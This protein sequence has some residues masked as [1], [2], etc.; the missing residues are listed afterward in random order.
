M[1]F[2]IL[3]LDAQGHKIASTEKVREVELKQELDYYLTLIKYTP[4]HT[5]TIKA[6][7]VDGIIL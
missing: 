3:L 5:I 7:T 4:D 2:D 1:R 6:V